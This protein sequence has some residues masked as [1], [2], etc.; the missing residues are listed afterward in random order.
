MPNALFSDEHD[1][2][3]LAWM[4]KE[5]PPH[6]KVVFSCQPD[7]KFQVLDAAKKLWGKQEENFIEVGKL[8]VSAVFPCAT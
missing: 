1:A 6:V 2:R 3:K 4:P 5:L 8:P 7:E